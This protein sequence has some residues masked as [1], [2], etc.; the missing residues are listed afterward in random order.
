MRKSSYNFCKDVL[1]DYRRTDEYIAKRRFQLSIPVDKD[2]NIG[3]GRS[4]IPGR[5]TERLAIKIAD[6]VYIQNLK[7]NKKA[8]DCTLNESQ[9]GVRELISLMYFGECK[10]RV[11]DV[12]DDAGFSLNHARVLHKHFLERL[13]DN[14]GLVK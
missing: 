11:V 14:L 2:E 5:P 6:D 4:N 10:K 13:A 7:F 8:I 3:G 9:E 1:Y 12:Y